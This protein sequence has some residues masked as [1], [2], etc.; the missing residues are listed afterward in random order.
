MSTFTR[1]LDWYELVGDKYRVKSPL[2]WE[3]ARVGS[4]YWMTVPKDFQFDLSVPRWL[5]W[6]VDPQDP[7]CLKAAAL[8]DFALQSGWERVSAAAVFNSALR[9]QKVNRWKRL[10]MVIAV[11][12]WKWE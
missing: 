4:G 6:L 7:T 2:Q 1:T 10:V 9:A 3:L 12:V 5:T 11:V 8:H